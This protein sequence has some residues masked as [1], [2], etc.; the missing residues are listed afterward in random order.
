MIRLIRLAEVTKQ[1]GIPTSTIY[2]MVRTGRFPAPVKL[3]ER[4]SAW[5]EDELAQWVDARTKA[6]RPAETA[7]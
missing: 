4:S 5:R 2:A 3:S 1:V 6:S 7:P